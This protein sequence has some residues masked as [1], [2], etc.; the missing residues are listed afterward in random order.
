[1]FE[2]TEVDPGVELLGDVRLDQS[3]IDHSEEH[4]RVLPVIR[5]Q[6]PRQRLAGGL[7]VAAI[8]AIGVAGPANVWA[9]GNG[10]GSG[11]G[12]GN[13]AGTP[14]AGGDRSDFALLDGTDP[15]ANE[16]GAQCAAKLGSSQN[17]VAFTYYVT[18]SNWSSSVK[19]LRVL[20]ADG[21]EMAR[22]QIPPNTSLASRKRLAGRRAWTTGSGYSPRAPCRPDLPAR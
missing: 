21:E 16:I 9:A 22:Y 7:L 8:A 6:S 18:V 11:F 15:T 4:M 17:A 5:P 2:E 14:A 10:F 12:N 19:I 20:Y 1:M 3:Q 13:G